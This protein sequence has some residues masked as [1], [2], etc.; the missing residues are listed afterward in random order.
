MEYNESW[1]YEIYACSLVQDWTEY[2]QYNKITE[3]I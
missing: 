1:K 3:G 2:G